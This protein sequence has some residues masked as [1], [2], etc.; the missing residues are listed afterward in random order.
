MD[1]K[2]TAIDLFLEQKFGGVD[3]K[4]LEENINNKIQELEL[5]LAEFKKQIHFFDSQVATSVKKIAKEK[6]IVKKGYYVEQKQVFA[7]GK[8]IANISCFIAIISIDI[9]SAKKGLY[10]EKTEWAKR[11][12]AKNLCVTLYEASVDDIFD[13]LGK[14]FK[15]IITNRIN[16]THIETEL[17]DIRKRLNIYRDTNKTFLYDVRTN[18]GAHKD[19]NSM[20]QLSTVEDIDWQHTITISLEFEKIINDLGSFLSKIRNLHMLNLQNS[21]IAKGLI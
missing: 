21:P 4:V 2:R 3:G 11:N 8:V 12:A 15:D 6:G 7:D 13:L 18:I 9:K 19:L 17:K 1:Y 20:K 5:Q 10:F 14:D 16:I